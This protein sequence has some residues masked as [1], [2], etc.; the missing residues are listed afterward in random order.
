MMITREKLKKIRPIELRTNRRRWR[1]KTIASSKGRGKLALTICR[2]TV[3]VL[4][5]DCLALYVSDQLLSP[6]SCTQLSVSFPPGAP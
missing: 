2:Q 5:S 4:I 3:R 1:G 6:G